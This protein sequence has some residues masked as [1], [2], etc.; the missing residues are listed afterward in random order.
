MKRSEAA[1]YSRWSAGVALFL[2]ALTLAVFAHR[3]WVR[4]AERRNAPPPAPQDVERLSTSINFSKMEGNQAV[5]TVEASKST[6]F[7]G[8]NA[9]LLED[10]KITIYGK[11]GERHDI[12]HTKS[13]RYSKEKGDIACAGEVQ[14]DLLSAADAEFLKKHPEQA[15]DRTMRVETRGVTFDRS[16]GLAETDQPVAFRF[17][18]GEGKAVGVEYNS[19]EGTLR[20]DRDV[21]IKLRQVSSTPGK[22]LQAGQEVTITGSRL[23]FGRD[24]RLLLLKGPAVAETQQAR[25]T[26]GLFH[27]ELDDNFRTKALVAL[28]K[29]ASGQPEVS[30]KGR[31]GQEIL[32]ADSFHAEFSPL[33]WVEIIEAAGN[34]QGQ[35]KTAG[36]SGTLAATQGKMELWPRD[37][38]PKELELHGAVDLRTE[39]VQ[40]GES[41][42]LKTEALKV[43]FSEPKEHE[44]NHALLAE[45]LAPGSLTWREHPPP[46]SAAGPLE[47]KIQAEKLALDFG[48]LGKARRLTANG[49]VKTERSAP[50][51]PLQTA[52]AQTGWVDLLPSGGWSQMNLDQNVHLKEG[53]RAAQAD[54]ALFVQATETATLSGHAFVRDPATATTANRISFVQNTGDMLAEG[55]VHSVDFSA[56]SSGVNLAVAPASIISDRLQANTKNGLALYSGHARFWQ[57]DSVLEAET[58]L[59]QRDER[60]LTAADK[61]RA[62]F[63]QNRPELQE[64]APA[65]KDIAVWHVSAGKLTYW[66]KENRAHLEN[67][68]VLQSAEERIRSDQMDLYFTRSGAAG[69]HVRASAQQISRAVADGNVVVEQG[70]RRASAEHGEYTAADGKFVMSGGN[71]TIFDAS[72]GTTTGR[73]LTFFLADDTIIVDSE[74]G[75]RTL[76]KH[77]VEN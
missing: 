32:R 17:P 55:G 38:V 20:L 13:C 54:H 50:G 5:F 10:V 15:A 2:A 24:S 74:K 27:V 68:V 63:L 25:L 1:K 16:S 40:R 59:L 69:E 12:L 35:L 37:N 30:F 7:R 42:E 34:L 36:Q 76:T 64:S 18:D 31:G 51:K 22:S 56:K 9:T 6:D 75:S 19:E 3:A 67:N 77:R 58:I 61:V 11:A 28:P 72:S 14:M 52:T 66:D 45:T 71:P 4:R 39:T 8:E 57:G 49:N 47:T 48:P 70:T 62:V 26:A 73:Q 21:R 44:A 43:S 65:K 23:D 46:A 41:R 33:G 29:D 60:M 53:D